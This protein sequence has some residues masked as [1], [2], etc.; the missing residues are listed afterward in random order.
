M[1]D[2]DLADSTRRQYRRRLDHALDAIMTLA[3]VTRDARR[4]CKRC[5]LS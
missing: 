1:A 5:A 4:L 3:P 2:A